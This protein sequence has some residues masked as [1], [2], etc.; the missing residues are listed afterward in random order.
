[1]HLWNPISQKHGQKEEPQESGVQSVWPPHIPQVCLH[2][3]GVVGSM[4]WHRRN[5][6]TRTLDAWGKTQLLLGESLLSLLYYYYY[7]C[8]D[9]TQHLQCKHVS[10]KI[11]EIFS[12]VSR[13]WTQVRTATCR[14]ASTCVRRYMA[15]YVVRKGLKSGNCVS[16][17]RIPHCLSGSRS[18]IAAHCNDC[19][20]EASRHW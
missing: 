8:N 17:N 11:I 5:W 18:S 3:A 15:P 14:R 6:H 12:L 2:P 13:M 16:G 20:Q 10:Q 1:M 7:Y 9:V 19:Q 4:L